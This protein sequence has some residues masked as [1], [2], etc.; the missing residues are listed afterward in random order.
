MSL[1]GV[2]GG[3]RSLVIVG[4]QPVRAGDDDPL[5]E[6]GVRF[7]VVQGAFDEAYAAL[8]PG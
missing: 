2:S 4:Q 3:R 7:A 1:P 5:S 8:A 6:L